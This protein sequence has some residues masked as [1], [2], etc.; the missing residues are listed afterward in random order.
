MS[1]PKI[2]YEPHPISS[3]RKRELRAQGYRIVDAKFDP[4]R[5]KQAK[6]SSGKK[7]TKASDEGDKE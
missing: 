3:E 7:Q 6:A 2:A 4:N 1:E 5:D